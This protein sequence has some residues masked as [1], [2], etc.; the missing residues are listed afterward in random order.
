[1]TEIQLL[2]VAAMASALLLAVAVNVAVAVVL[3][4]VRRVLRSR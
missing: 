1:M 2:H 3:F 4:V